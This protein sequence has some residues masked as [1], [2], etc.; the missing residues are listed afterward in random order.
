MNQEKRPIIDLETPI[1]PIR[2]SDEFYQLSSQEQFYSYYFYKAGWEGAKICYFQRSF[3]SPALFC[4]ITLIF[5]EP[6]Q[7]IRAKC[8]LNGLVESDL[9]KILVYVASVLINCGNYKSF[10]DTKFIP[11]V[12]IEI[13]ETFL[14]STTSYETHKALIDELWSSIAVYVYSYEG[15]YKK[16]GYIKI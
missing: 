10:G 8:L 2:C 6:I 16:I 5:R 4:L 15:E 9:Q 11:E 3:E 1:L 7:S 14:H 13:F 12:N